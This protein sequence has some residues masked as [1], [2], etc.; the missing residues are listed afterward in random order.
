M[1]RKTSSLSYMSTKF[2]LSMHYL[3]LYS[4][5]DFGLAATKVECKKK[6]N[7]VGTP[8]YQAPELLRRLPH[9][10]SVD[11]WALGCIILE[12]VSFSSFMRRA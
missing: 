3:W 5:A 8:L 11:F 12:M 2:A 6:G 7:L 10:S 1:V 9:D 4:L